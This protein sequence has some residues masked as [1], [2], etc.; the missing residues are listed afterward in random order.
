VLIRRGL[1]KCRLGQRAG[2]LSG[3]AKCQCTGSR[4]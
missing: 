3:S 1:L 2:D 4:R